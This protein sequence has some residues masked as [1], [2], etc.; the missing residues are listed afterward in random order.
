MLSSAR[1]YL[2]EHLFGSGNGDSRLEAIRAEAAATEDALPKQRPRERYTYAKLLD[3]FSRL[4]WT[5][6][7]DV[8]K[9][10]RVCAPLVGSFVCD[11]LVDPNRV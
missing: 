10:V 7:A 1:A 5:K 2:H 6:A 4:D 3:V 11:G 9:A 8:E